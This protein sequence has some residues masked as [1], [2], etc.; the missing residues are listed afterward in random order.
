M[1]DAVTEIGMIHAIRPLLTRLLDRAYRIRALPRLLQ[2]RAS[3]RYFCTIVGGLLRA[4]GASVAHLHQA[5][6]PTTCR[7]LKSDHAPISRLHLIL[8]SRKRVAWEGHSRRLRLW[9]RVLQ[10]LPL[11]LLLQSRLVQGRVVLFLRHLVLHGREEAR[12]DFAIAPPE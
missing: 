1:P 10:V 8:L 12:S 3:D 11:V 7:H 6:R 4:S 9:L 2:P 5:A